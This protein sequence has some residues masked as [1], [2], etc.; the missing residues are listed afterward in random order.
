VADARSPYE[1]VTAEAERYRNALMWVRII[2]GM[3]Y[4]GGAFEPEHMRD[5]AN[6]AARAL[7]GQDLPDC[8]SLTAESRRRAQAEAGEWG[9]LLAEEQ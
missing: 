5:L 7:D 4:Y 2:T 1:Q 6:L 9:R 8:E 3:H